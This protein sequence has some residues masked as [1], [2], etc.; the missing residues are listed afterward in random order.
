MS[1]ILRGDPWGEQ[2]RTGGPLD[3]FFDGLR[4]S[5][6][7]LRI[8]RLDDDNLWFVFWAENGADIQVEAMDGGLPPFLV[9]SDYEGLDTADP[10][11]ALS[12]A[13]RWLAAPASG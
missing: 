1:V 6:V 13:R 8:E 2:D 9:E 10:E 11:E 5:F 12:V 3:D 7:G 4:A